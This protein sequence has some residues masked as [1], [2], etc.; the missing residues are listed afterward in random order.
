[1][2]SDEQQDVVENFNRIRSITRAASKRIH[3]EVVIR[4]PPQSKTKG[5]VKGRRPKGGGEKR[6]KSEFE[7]HSGK[8]RKHNCCK[9][10]NVGHDS[11]NCPLNR[12]VNQ[13][14]TKEANIARY[15]FQCFFF[16]Y[17]LCC[18]IHVDIF[19]FLFI[20]G[21]QQQSLLK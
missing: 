6:W 12:D 16:C 15:V 13:G 3:A 18:C 9:K 1:M 20:L 14:G 10:Y 5:S 4:V 8:R 2:S 7:K 11:R 17:P 19:H 21:T